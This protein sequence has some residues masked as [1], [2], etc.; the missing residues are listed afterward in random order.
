MLQDIEEDKVLAKA[1]TDLQR[2]WRGLISRRHT[3]WLR[4]EREGRRRLSQ[5]RNDVEAERERVR[6]LEKEAKDRCMLEETR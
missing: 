3:R 6:G 1:S 4:M 5:L 2:C